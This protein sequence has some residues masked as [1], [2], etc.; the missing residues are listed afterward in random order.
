MYFVCVYTTG[1]SVW[2][3]LKYYLHGFAEEEKP[4][5]NSQEICVTVLQCFGVCTSVPLKKID[6]YIIWILLL[7][8]KSC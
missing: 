6:G 1:R 2:L 5:Y 8:L 7:A 4:L 3:L